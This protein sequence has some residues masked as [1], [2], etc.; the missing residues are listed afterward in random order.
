MQKAPDPITAKDLF[1]LACRV[2]ALWELIVSAEYGLTVFNIVARL[3]RVPAG[4]TFASYLV[5]TIGTCF[6]GIVLLV[7]AP[8]LA[9]LFYS[10]SSM[11][12]TSKQQP[13]NS[14]KPSI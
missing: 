5:Q 10:D 3:A 6:I 14:D 8:A 9:H 13:D 1:I 11:S 2:L 12:D 7:G 4:Y